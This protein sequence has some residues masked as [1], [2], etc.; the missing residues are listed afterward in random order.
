MS[1]KKKIICEG[2]EVGQTNE[3]LQ[4]GHILRLASGVQ[5][6]QQL[7]KQY[8][9]ESVQDDKVNVRENPLLG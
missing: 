8:T 1:N 7:T 3:K 4:Q 2:Q 5:D 6:G 9:V